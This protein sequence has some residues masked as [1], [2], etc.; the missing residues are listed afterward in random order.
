MHYISDTNNLRILQKNGEVGTSSGKAL[1]FYNGELTIGDPA[2]STAGNVIIPNLTATDGTALQIVNA[3][4]ASDLEKIG[5]GTLGTTAAI[6]GQVKGSFYPAPYK[7]VG[8]SPGLTIGLWYVVVVGP[9]THN[10]IVYVTGQRFK[11]TA[12]ANFSGANTIVYQDLDANL[13]SMGEL[14]QRAENFRIANLLVG[15]EAVYDEATK[16]PTPK[17]AGWTR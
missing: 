10:S 7:T 13:W 11:A 2:L 4:G 17:A 3:T 1:R 5:Q 6:A 12:T 15:D 9:I 8:A 16:A 14:N